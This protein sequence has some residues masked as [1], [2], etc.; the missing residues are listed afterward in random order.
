MAGRYALQTR[1]LVAV[2]LAAGIVATVGILTGFSF[3]STTLLQEAMRRVE[4]DLGSAWAAFEEERARLRIVVGIT[5]QNDSLRRMLRA[6][7]DTGQVA[8]ELEGMRQ[9]YELDFLNVVDRR[10]EGPGRPAM[11]AGPAGTARWVDSIVTRALEGE[12]ASGTILIPPEILR[13]EREALAERALVPL[14]FTEKA[15]PTSRT[16]EERGM[17]VEAAFPVLDDDSRVLGAVYGGVLVNRRFDLVD[18]IRDSVFG[19]K[20][21]KGRP[22]G[23]VTF[24]LADVRVATNVMLDAGTRALGTRVSQQV[25]QTVLDGGRRF[26]DRAFVVNDWYLSAYDPIRDPSGSIIGIIYVGLLEKKYLDYKSSLAVQYLAISAFGLLLSVVVASTLASQI[27]R[28]I[29][30]LVAATRSLSAGNLGTRVKVGPASREV[31][32]LAAAFNRM[33]EVLETRTLEVERATQ[34]LIA[35][36]SESRERNRA[37]R[38]TLGFVTHELKSPL[39]SIVLGIEAIRDGLLGPVTSEQESVLRSAAH[40]AEYLRDTIGNY[41]NLN[42]IEEGALELKLRPVRFAPEVIRPV[43]ERFTKLAEERSMRITCEVPE[44]LVGTCDPALIGSVFQNL[45][46]NAVKYASAGGEIRI[47]GARSETADSVRF[48]VWN[49]GPGFEPED[50][51]KMFQKFVRLAAGADTRSGTGLGL[52]VSDQIV[53]RHGGKIWAESEPGRW[54]CFLFELP[55]SPPSPAGRPPA[56]A[57]TRL[58]IRDTSEPQP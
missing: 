58:R 16:V 10:G 23:T 1:L 57:V 18:R 22:V 41:L 43:V 55:G 26:A 52:F 46:S 11:A 56:A 35:A 44:D 31:A 21:Y 54:A 14:V 6:T 32:E 19:D 40:S 48:E 8:Q 49:E 27:R 12:A 30:R 29:L 7:S 13:R 9:R 4:V 34:E 38:E 47:R 17:V 42:R 25:K 15:A 3:L 5:A 28:P 50:G 2:L 20:T 36:Y 53:R 24:F 33:A 39:A 51:E 37:Y 45:V